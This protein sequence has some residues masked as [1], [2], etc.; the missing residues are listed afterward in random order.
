MIKDKAEIFKAINCINFLNTCEEFLN[1]LKLYEIKFL[2]QPE[3][4]PVE[5]L[6]FANIDIPIR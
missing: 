6:P 2:S 5:K 4:N 3:N 1:H